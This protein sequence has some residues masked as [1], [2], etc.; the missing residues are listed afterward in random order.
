MNGLL[1]GMMKLILAEQTTTNILGIGG[2]IY[3]SHF[4]CQSQKSE[5]SNILTIIH[6]QLQ[7]TIS[8][9]LDVLTNK[10]LLNL[11]HLKSKKVHLFSFKKYTRSLMKTKIGAWK[12]PLSKQPH[13]YQ[14]IKYSLNKQQQQQQQQQRLKSQINMPK[15]TP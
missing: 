12:I 11:S 10:Y 2:V 13:M 5:K 3:L 6:L 14:T 9:H 15:N 4:H 1:F 8:S 7:W